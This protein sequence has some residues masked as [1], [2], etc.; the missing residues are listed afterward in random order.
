MKVINIFSALIICLFF[1]ACEEMNNVVNPGDKPVIEAYLAPGQIVSMKVFTEIPYSATDSAFSK[2][3]TDLAIK[4]ELSDGKTFNLAHE[5]DGIYKS[6]EKITGGV[7]TTIKMSF[8]HNGRTVSA[9]TIIPPKPEGLSMDISEITRAS[10]DFSTRP[11]PGQGGG[12]LQEERTPVNV[13]WNNPENVYHFLAAQSLEENPVSV[14]VFP[15]NGGFG[16][17]PS[18]RFN[19]E[20]VQTTGSTLQSQSFEYFGKY[21]IILYRLNPDYAALFVNNSTTSQNISTPIS[22]ISN[23]LGIFTG[24]NADTLVFNVKKAN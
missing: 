2:P 21:G 1:G 12:F 8:A 20:P 11:T 3:I 6:T 23:G 9:S 7:G 15:T 14:V 4:I 5:S 13:T 18:R 22:E 16:P 19:N 17:L 10:R 24:I